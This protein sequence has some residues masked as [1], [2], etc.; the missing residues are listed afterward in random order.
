MGRRLKV[1]TILA[2]D[3]APIWW[4]P[5]TCNYRSNVSGPHRHL[6]T[7]S[8]HEF[9]E[10]CAH[11][12]TCNRLFWWWAAVSSFLCLFSIGQAHCRHQTNWLE[13][14]QDI[15]IGMVKSKSDVIHDR[16]HPSVTSSNHDYLLRTDTAW[17]PGCFLCFCLAPFRWF[18]L[19]HLHVQIL[20][21]TLS[22]LVSPSAIYCSRV[23]PIP[24]YMGHGICIPTP[25][26]TNE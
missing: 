7:H 14:R 2:G 16:T 25:Q 19:V 9:T 22:S 4:F 1:L 11:V 18:P 10:R 23:L 20:P 15:Y 6:Y 12:H 5:K 26:K 24:S 8:A 17:V 3:L 21:S 13:S